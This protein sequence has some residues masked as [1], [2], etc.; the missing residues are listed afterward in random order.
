MTAHIETI[1]DTRQAEYGG[2]ENVAATSQALKDVMRAAPNWSK[3]NPAQR[4]A[5]EMVQHKIA[6]QLNGV[7]D[8]PDTVFDIEG[9]SRLNRE[10]SPGAT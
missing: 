8:Q 9:Y 3:L 10:A 2:F 7:L 6:R 5:L 4:E 1:L